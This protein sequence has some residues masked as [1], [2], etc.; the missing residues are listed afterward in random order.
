MPGEIEALLG[1]ARD[2]LERG[3][4]AAA[5]TSFEDALEQGESAE[6]LLGLADTLIWLGETADAIR[7]YERAYAVARKRSDPAQAALATIGLYLLYRVSL[8]N[9]AASRG[10]LARGVR[11]VDDFELGPLAGWV[12]LLR[13]HDVGDPAQAED[14]SREARELGRALGDGDLELCA[15]SQTGV[16][17]VERGRTDQGVAL[18]DE[19]LAA[20][21]GGEGGRDTVVWTSCNMITCC[22]RAAE[23]E[24]A[25]QWIRVGDDFTERYGSPHLY[26][27]CRLHLGNVLFSTG[28]WAEAERELH[29]AI[30]MSKRGERAIHVEALAKLAELRL[31][32]GRLEE[33]TRL[34]EGH[35][36]E[37]ATSFVLGAI[38]LAHGKPGLTLSIARRRLRA[39]ADGSLESAGMLELLSA[40]EIEQDALRAATASA[41]RLAAL[42]ERLDSEVV[43]ARGQRAVGRALV[44]AG[45]GD[46]AVPHL[47]RALDAFVR[48]ELRLDAG[49]SHLLLARALTR[50]DPD[51]AIA[52]AR[53][54]RAC[55]EVLG[56]NRDGDEAAAV[57]RALGVKGARFA[58][59]GEG[60][61]TKREGEILEL[62]AEGLSNRAM[63]E[64]LFLSPKT[65]EHHVRS[66]LAKLDLTNRAEAAAYAVRHAERDSAGR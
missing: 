38:H 28:R 49:R 16:A 1:A 45:A 21:L 58:P 53:A 10:W 7:C 44:A 51:G 3:D 65:V 11:L 62:L 54:A 40:A 4:W 31:C 25:S 57:L 43:V 26:S 61:L 22:S 50:D 47:E 56:A 39:L 14:W 9:V 19:A 6:T 46:S 30:E 18:L 29:T 66:V 36:D 20:S 37:E 59:R 2:A 60:E 8:A 34:V 35:D 27:L 41:R 64:R 52:E 13:A 48:L 12:L 33:A 42:G 55:F 24:R 5:R 63:A 32:Q 23:F 17:L 15:L